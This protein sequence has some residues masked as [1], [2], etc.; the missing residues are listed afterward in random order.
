M[1]YAA[2][3]ESNMAKPSWCLEVMTMYFMPASLAVRTHS[4]A[5]NLTG[6][7]SL[8]KCAVFGDGDLA[9][10]HDPLADTFDLLALVG[11]G[12]D[13]IDAPMDEHAEAGLAPPFHAGVALGRRFGERAISRQPAPGRK[14]SLRRQ[15]ESTTEARE[16]CSEWLA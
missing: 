11:A 3:C 2:P 1:L 4:S 13:R 5:L 9:V 16:T 14:R 7:N 10:V 12:R 15:P 6:L 8:A